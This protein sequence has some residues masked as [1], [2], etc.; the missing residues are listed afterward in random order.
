MD[1]ISFNIDDDL[2]MG[3]VEILPQRS[4]VLFEKRKLLGRLLAIWECLNTN[5]GDVAPMALE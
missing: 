4:N 2:G 1:Q 3:S 5:Y